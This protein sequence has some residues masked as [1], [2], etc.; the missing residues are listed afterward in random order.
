MKTKTTRRIY[1]YI[2]I[3]CL[4]VF[5]IILFVS[6]NHAENDTIDDNLICQSAQRAVNYLRRLQHDNGQIILVNYK[7]FNVWET[8]QAARAI[9][10]W[11]NKTDLKRHPILQSALTFLKNSETSFGMVLHNSDHKNSYCIETSSEYIRLLAFLENRNTIEHGVAGKKASY[12]KSKQ[13]PSGAWR[14]ESSAIPE[15]LQ[16]FP[17]VTGF[18]LGALAS[19]NT[20]PL[21]L[22]AALQYL[23]ESQN[24]E[25]H[26][27]I[28]WQY[29]GTPYYAMAPIL[30]A[31]HY[32]NADSSFDAVINKAKNFLL[33]SQRKDGSFS[34]KSEKNQNRPS[35]ELETTLGL[36]SLLSCNAGCDDI[37][38]KRGINWLLRNQRKDGSWNGGIFPLPNPRYKKKEDIFCTSQVL[39]LLYE[40]LNIKDK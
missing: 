6:L 30:E 16:R 24:E 32:H 22:D 13:L 20:A 33:A 39:I 28:V 3:L 9:S 7:V 34:Y 19:T 31:M 21:D 29:Y 35:V 27:G 18:A 10:L 26:W 25:G 8:I 37:G 15:Y 14:I 40:Y 11:Q 12:M 5:S 36:R 38:I 1:I 2:L 17:S 23:K 4:L